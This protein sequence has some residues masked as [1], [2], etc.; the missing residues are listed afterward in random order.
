M[1]DQNFT[2]A[3]WT[4]IPGDL[5][6][7]QENEYFAG[8]IR[9]QSDMEWSIAAVWK[10]CN[11]NKLEEGVEA[12]ANALLIAAAPKLASK[13]TAL[14][15]W[16]GKD[17]DGDSMVEECKELLAEAGCPFEYDEEEND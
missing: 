12:S 16:L 6:C 13:L 11:Q 17:W 3:P 2:P 7:G 14:I 8:D 5:S 4:Y 10:D 1:K 15:E 9:S